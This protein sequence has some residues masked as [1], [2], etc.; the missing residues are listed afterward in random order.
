MPV[1]GVL[2]VGSADA[3]ARN[4]AAFRKGLDETGYDDGRNVTIEYH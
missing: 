4:V 1:V 3:N 2:R